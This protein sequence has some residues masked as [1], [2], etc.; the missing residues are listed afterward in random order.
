MCA[1]DELKAIL[2]A[3]DEPLLLVTTDARIISCT[4]R[5]AALAPFA[6]SGRLDGSAGGA[7]PEMLHFLARCAAS[8]SPLAS[9]LVPNLP[10]SA[11]SSALR[12]VGRGIRFT[13]GDTLVLLRVVEPCDGCGLPADADPDW[14]ARIER[15]ER[16]R[17]AR[18]LHDQAGQHALCLKLGLARLRSQCG[19]APMIGA[20]DTLL[21]QVDSMV[22]DLHRAIVELRPSALDGTDFTQALRVYSARWSD[23]NGVPVKFRVDGV[24]GPLTTECEAA[25]FRVLQEALTNV[26]KHAT[27]V[28][29]V[30]V[31]LL[32]ADGCA[33]LT[34]RDDGRGLRKKDRSP[35]L[36]IRGGRLGLAGMHERMA[37]LGG[38][39]EM[40]SAN[41]CSG[42]TVVAR[43]DSADC[44][45][46]GASHAL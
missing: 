40:Q 12:F 1:S 19:D 13:S 43:I 24:P 46:P 23:L 25:L 33:T 4:T 35:S 10:R 6:D 29:S 7:D 11:V 27:G 28:R 30:D 44:C 34:I 5:A 22:A 8:A 32:H 3:I 42:T 41:S 45:L 37:Y 38:A 17:I 31:I 26:A 16:A 15:A 21:C 2:E 36:F 18:D 39:L 20:I 9:T 14:R